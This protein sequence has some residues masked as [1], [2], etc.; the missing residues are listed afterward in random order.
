MRPLYHGPSTGNVSSLMGG[1][2]ARPEGQQESGKLFNNLLIFI[3]E[4]Q[5]Y[6][7]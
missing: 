5:F 7:K 6:R 3:R 2:H 1:V 4:I